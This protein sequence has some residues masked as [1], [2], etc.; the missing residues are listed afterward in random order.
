VLYE[1]EFSDREWRD[2]L[3]DQ[4]ERRFSAEE[5]ASHARDL[6]E[7]TLAAKGDIDARI[8][9]MLQNWDL[10]RLSLI[11]KNIL[12]FA[13][14]EMLFFPHIPTKVIIDEALEI[15]NKYSS[16]DAGRLVNGLL[17]RLARE[18]RTSEL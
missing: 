16:M 11:D 12:R 8:E 18:I 5:T 13:C 3:L 15:A 17:D 6:L 2:V 10:E 9:S 14:A 7:A 4:T 1:L